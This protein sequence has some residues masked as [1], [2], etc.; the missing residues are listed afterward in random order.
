[1]WLLDKLKCKTCD[2][3][4][5]R[6]SRAKCWQL[7]DQCGNC[8]FGD[9]PEAFERTVCKTRIS[10][11]YSIACSKCGNKTATLRLYVNRG[12][13]KIGASYCFQCKIMKITDNQIKIE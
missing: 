10:K 13:S 12:M 1:M 11:K 5:R 9:H 6:T 4:A 3:R 2:F 7:F 8:A